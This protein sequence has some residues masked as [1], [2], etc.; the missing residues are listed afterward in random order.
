MLFG[1][2]GFHPQGSRLKQ[3]KE[4]AISIIN[5]LVHTDTVALVSF[6]SL[7]RSP[8]TVLVQ[9]TDSYRASMIVDVQKM[10]PNGKTYY[11]K[12]MDLAFDIVSKSRSE[13]LPYKLGCNTVFLFLTDGN[14]T[15]EE[16]V[17]LQTT[18]GTYTKVLMLS[19]S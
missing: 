18:I 3:A 19:R 6:S 8:N 10:E 11:N 4:A 15:E 7:A 5:S 14:P 13:D 16:E 9:A 2:T 1:I 12:A 17:T